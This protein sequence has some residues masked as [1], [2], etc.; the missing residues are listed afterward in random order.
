[1]TAALVS[2]D[3]VTKTF[4][5]STVLSCV[6]LEIFRGECLFVRGGNGSGKST[7]LKLAAGLIAPVSG[8]RSVAGSPGPVIGYAPDRLPGLP[9][10]SDAY[11]R[12][13]GRIAGI[14][15]KKLQERI[16]ELHELFQLKMGDPTLMKHYSKGMLQKTNLMQATLREPDLLVL[17]EP[18]SGLD[19][20]TAKQLVDSLSR[21]QNQ[22]TALLA[23]VHHD[24]PEGQ[25]PGRTFRITDGKLLA[26]PPNEADQHGKRQ[27]EAIYEVIYRASKQDHTKLTAL[28]PLAKLHEQENECYRCEIAE[29]DLKLLMTELLEGEGTLV[30]LNRK[31]IAQGVDS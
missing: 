20:G 2:L 19:Q 13:M 9:L 24:I 14:S 15:N 11:L 25:L 5:K 10:T 30:S 26:A 28:F 3:N 12:Y 1:M 16:P 23:A 17:D 7:L 31:E 22:G 4:G 21:L 8:L 27:T 18:F 6:T 29:R